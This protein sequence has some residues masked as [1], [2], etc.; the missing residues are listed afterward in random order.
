MFF[1]RQQRYS[2]RKYKVGVFS[3]FLGSFI[4]SVPLAF[5]NSQA[6]AFEPSKTEHGNAPSVVD[7][8]EILNKVVLSEEKEIIQD[9]EQ[10]AVADITN[11]S[12]ND[13]ERVLK[14]VLKANPQLRAEMV[15]VGSDGT[16][17]VTYKDKVYVIDKTVTVRL[18]EKLP[19]GASFRD[20]G[21]VINPNGEPSNSEYEWTRGEGN[22]AHNSVDTKFELLKDGREIKVTVQFNPHEDAWANPLYYLT[23]PEKVER[24]IGIDTL[25]SEPLT[26]G[27]Y[28]ETAQGYA[29]D[30]PVSEWISENRTGSDFRSYS[31]KNGGQ[32]YY[33][34][35]LDRRWYDLIGWQMGKYTSDAERRMGED[36]KKETA[37]ILVF[38]GGVGKFK[39]VFEYRAILKEPIRD[40]SELPMMIGFK[41]YQNSQ[42][43]A[44]AY[45]R[46]P[47][48]L[49]VNGQS[50]TVWSDEPL[51][52]PIVIGHTEGYPTSARLITNS[53]DT[54]DEVTN[55]ALG[56]TINTK[57][58]EKDVVLDAGSVILGRDN[59]HTSG[60]T[61]RVRVDKNGKT[62]AVSSPIRISAVHA[63]D[64]TITKQS[65]Q[66]TA[67]NDIYGAVQATYQRG[68]SDV[69]WSKV[70]KEIIEVRTPT[71]ELVD[72][73]NLSELPEAQNNKVKVRLTLPSGHQ[74][75][76]TV[77]VNYPQKVTAT[78][79]S[80]YYVWADTVTN[81]DFTTGNIQG[82]DGTVITEA[83]LTNGGGDVSRVQTYAQGDT[84]TS[85]FSQDNRQ[86]TFKKGSLVRGVESTQGM[87]QYTLR[88]VAGTRDSNRAAISDRFKIAALVVTNPTTSIDKTEGEQVTAEEIKNKVFE[89]YKGKLMEADGKVAFD[90]KQESIKAVIV[91]S[92]DVDTAMETTALPTSGKNNKV[93]VKLTTPSGQD[94]IVTVIVNY[95]E[96]VDTDGDGFP[97]VE[98]KEKGSNP[99]DATSTPNTVDTDGDGFP[100]VEEKEKGSNPNDATSTPNTVDTDGDGFPDVEEKEKGSNPNDATST[101]NTVD[102]DGDGFP[103][104]EEK[105]K[106]SNPNDA[107]STPNSKPHK[108]H[109]E[110]GVG[111]VT[112]D[113][114]V[115]NLDEDSDHDGF[116]NREELENG[117]DPFD[118][119]SHPKRYKQSGNIGVGSKDKSENVNVPNELEDT[120][121]KSENQLPHTGEATNHLGLFVGFITLG[122][123]GLLSKYKKDEE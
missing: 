21:F 113:K 107:T 54:I 72:K 91:N 90:V 96:P 10:I 101:P 8:N 75:V 30:N 53:Q 83:H 38:R 104:V 73:N 59:T 68:G 66:P 97:D 64:T 16:V 111:L 1:K 58:K 4:L 33:K 22:V 52:K 44:R 106:G 69:D 94:K 67:E 49:E 11:L 9:P 116:T 26:G 95:P 2:I 17:S 118:K 70:T 114:P 100:D 78:E 43:F 98:E 120:V 37:G 60:Y 117:T 88:A 99:N 62:P 65:G 36:I 3:V 41:S 47:V 56:D 6:N 87:S 48:P 108:G 40:I 74:K 39:H 122:L 82:V 61:V 20:G 57:L 85:V 55:P 121:S 81:N 103:D 14:R 105:E 77:T 32:G 18:A 35:N 86:V 27:R 12:A 28:K 51:T 71:G 93:Y 50:G 19:E 23:I 102:T 34:D 5:S 110:I 25:T 29:G 24:I 84:V 13:K 89:T 42:N 7:D 45:M 15:T 63:T 46:I 31:S 76:V 112:P 119:D 79:F 92:D 109:H 115:L 123:S 80:N